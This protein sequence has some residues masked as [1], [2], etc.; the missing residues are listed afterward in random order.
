MGKICHRLKNWFFDFEKKLASPYEY[1]STIDDYQKPANKLKKEDSFSKSKNV[2][3][4]DEEKERRNETTKIFILKLGE[5][6]TNIHL[7]SDVFY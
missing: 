5:N 4:R 3:L 6:L 1:F 7:K 2:C